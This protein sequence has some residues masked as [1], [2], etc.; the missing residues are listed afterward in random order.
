MDC[1]CCDACHSASCQAWQLRQTSPTTSG[2]RKTPRFLAR[3][4]VAGFRDHKSSHAASSHTG[5]QHT[6]TAHHFQGVSRLALPTQSA[7]ILARSANS[8]GMRAC[9]LK[10]VWRGQATSGL[11]RGI[12][13]TPV[14]AT[15]CSCHTSRA[16]KGITLCSGRREVHNHYSDIIPRAAID[17]SARQHLSKLHAGQHLQAC[18]FWQ[19]VHSEVLEHSQPHRLFG[20]TTHCWPLR[21]YEHMS[22]NNREARKN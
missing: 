19:W 8:A 10:I 2:C 9:T 22:S 11:G 5:L 6:V 16:S 20:I 7:R 4:S 17:C 1:N 12:P 18:I 15:L 13:A 21:N 14:I 3:A